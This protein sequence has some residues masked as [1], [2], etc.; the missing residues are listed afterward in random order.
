M[1]DTNA[2]TGTGH[3]FVDNSPFL[4]YQLVYSF[5]IINIGNTG[6]QN[7]PDLNISNTDFWKA[8]NQLARMIQSSNYVLSVLHRRL[9]PSLNFSLHE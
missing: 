8:G 2:R 3:D 6:N 7:H 4:H 1:G 9:D 5:K